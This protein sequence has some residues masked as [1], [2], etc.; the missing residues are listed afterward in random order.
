MLN[1]NPYD[2]VEDMLVGF[3]NQSGST[4][5]SLA[6]SGS[7]LFGF[8]GDGLQT[9]NSS[10]GS[11]PTGYG[12]MTSTGQDVTFLV[13]NANLGSVIFGSSGLASGA[14]AYFSLEGGPTVNLGA[15]TPLPTSALSFASAVVGFGFLARKHLFR[16]NDRAGKIA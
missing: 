6:L 10:L 8:D 13:S 9:Y 11:D 12:G 15:S 2:G 7:N 3:Q 14:S 16:S 1:P 4:R 5:S